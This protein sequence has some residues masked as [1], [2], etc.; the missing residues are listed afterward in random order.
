MKS[1]LPII[2]IAVANLLWS[3]IPVVV[4]NLFNDVS[5]IMVIFL[6]FFIS[7]IVL[8]SIGVII[9]LYNN[10]YTENEKI[11][12]KSLIKFT[13]FRNEAFFNMKNIFYFA[14]IGFFGIILQ[15]IG[16]FMSLKTTSIAFTM[17]G[18]QI[19][20]IL[21]AFYEHGVRSERLDLFK[22]LYLLLLVVTVGIII[23]VKSQTLNQTNNDFSLSGFSYLVL[24][25]ISL[26]F[27]H[28]GMTRESYDK[29]EIKMINKNRIYKMIRFLFKLSFIFLIGILIMIPFLL[30]IYMIPIESE[31]NIEIS[32]FFNEFPFIFQILSRW[33]VIFLI[34]FATIL[35]FSLLFLARVNWSAYNLTY[36]QWSSILTIIE[37]IGGIFFGIL[38]IG[39]Y[40][41]SE[42]LIII[43][44]LLIIS[45]LFRYAHE[46]KNKVNAIVI[47]NKKQGILKNLAI[48]LLKLDGIYSVESILGT[49]DLLVNIKTNSIKDLYYLIDTQI[50]KIEGVIDIKILFINKIH[51]I[52][53]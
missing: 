1:K 51:K 16:Y 3:F 15:I 19:S 5:T 43:L 46:S 39:E 36:S 29:R 31:L 14:I 38:I 53:I 20:I 28:I 44:F 13:S 24:F 48:K 26:A 25:S 30:I 47:L 45:I 52:N 22:I 21:V 4:F 32:N 6:R 23:Y 37:P 9:L 11:P 12:L 2:Y 41:P 35:P 27:L 42:F 7:G 34:I 8:F 10:N 49:H 40:F 18:F 50:K 17:M 33:E